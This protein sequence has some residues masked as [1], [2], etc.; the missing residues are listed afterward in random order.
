MKVKGL[1]CHFMNSVEK[2]KK[3]KYLSRNKYI[4][5][6]TLQCGSVSSDKN[7]Y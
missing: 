1:A 7:A 4:L 5:P 2:S 6:F 3:K